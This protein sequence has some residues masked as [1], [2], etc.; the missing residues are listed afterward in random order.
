MPSLHDSITAL[1][2]QDGDYLIE[3]PEQWAQG[4]TLFGGMTAALSHAAILRAYGDL[5]PL[6]NAQFSFVGPASGPLAFRPT[7]LRRGRSSAI[8]A[9]DCRNEE[10]LAARATFSFAG[11]RESVVAH[12]YRPR[13]IVPPPEE[14][15]RFHRTTKP[16]PGFLA[17]FEFRF[18]SGTRL[19]E[20]VADSAPPEFA[21]WIRFREAAGEDRVTTLLALADALPGAA[22]VQFPRPAPLST[23]TWS[24]DFHQPLADA[25]EWNL[26]WT[27]SEVA[28]DGYSLQNMRVYNA[29]GDPLLSAQQ[30]VAIFI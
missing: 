6:R 11:P 30:V 2:E 5:G 26:V 19:F 8:V 7:L 21:L 10:G 24:V 17:Q 22:M 27:S 29:A 23:L 3:A 9:V 15:D 1:A 16:L 13:M 4:R 25:S 14:C 12:D 28:A 18:A 20:G